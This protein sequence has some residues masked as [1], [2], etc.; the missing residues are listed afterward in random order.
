MPKDFWEQYFEHIRSKYVRPSISRPR[1]SQIRSFELRRRS[2]SDKFF[3][4]KFDA[5]KFHVSKKFA[6][7]YLLIV[8]QKFCNKNN[9][10]RF[11]KFFKVLGKFLRVYLVFGKILILLQQKRY[12]IGHVFI[13][14]DGPIFKIIQPSG[15]TEFTNMRSHDYLP[16]YISFFDHFLGKNV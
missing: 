5:T 11:G 13:V 12:T 2:K 3:S 6:Q 4:L 1:L 16:N 9:V 15:H 7:N 10:T 14:V 8:C